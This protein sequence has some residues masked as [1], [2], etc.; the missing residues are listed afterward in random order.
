LY[1]SWHEPPFNAAGS[2]GKARG[3]GIIAN[4]GGGI[5]EDE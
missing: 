3:M 4:E 5:K 1:Y 2:R